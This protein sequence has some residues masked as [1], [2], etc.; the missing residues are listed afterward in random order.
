MHCAFLPPSTGVSRSHS[1]STP[2][3]LPAHHLA[4]FPFSPLSPL[5]HPLSR[6]I[7]PI[8][9][10]DS[11]ITHVGPYRIDSPF[12][13]HRPS[14]ATH[15]STSQ[16]LR[17]HVPAFAMSAVAS[18]SKRP[19]GPVAGPSAKRS[20]P[21][22]STS[23]EPPADEHLDA[24]VD[25]DFDV[26]DHDHD[27]T[28]EVDESTRAK[29]A[30]KEARV[31]QARFTLALWHITLP[32]VRVLFASTRLCF[33]LCADSFRPSGI[34]SL[35]NDHGISARPTSFGSK[36]A[37]ANSKRRTVRSEA[38]LHP[39]RHRLA[40]APRRTTATRARTRRLRAS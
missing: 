21:S 14:P 28:G 36:P 32:P 33:V 4:L 1:T 38:M 34:A 37:W 13:V 31:S 11:L 30:R 12:I 17:S 27:E 22:T 35:P 8:S 26:E 39:R 10:L 9:R 16:T 6:I 7:P 2:V 15:F 40:W 29:V 18:S 19:A 3:P 25:V 5:G 23:S 20:R 24:E